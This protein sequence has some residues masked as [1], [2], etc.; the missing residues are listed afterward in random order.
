MPKVSENRKMVGRKVIEQ[1]LNKE[2]VNV[3]KAM[4]DVGYADNT[5][6]AKTGEVVKSL[7][8]QAETK[9][10]L[11]QMEELI[12][13]NIKHAKEKQKKASFRDSIETI[14]RLKKLSRDIAGVP[15]EQRMTIKWEE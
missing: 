1:I 10:F 13:N 4:R 14:D 3:S 15:T 8:F 11:A 6:H 2:K 5:I 9:D 7:E 12:Q